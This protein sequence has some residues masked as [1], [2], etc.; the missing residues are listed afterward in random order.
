MRI[1][2]RT[3]DEKKLFGVC[4]GLGYFTKVDPTIWRLIFVGLIFT[5]FPICTMYIIT[6]LITHS[7]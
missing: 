4:G 3:K 1:Y 5:P 7:R 6:S 2:Y